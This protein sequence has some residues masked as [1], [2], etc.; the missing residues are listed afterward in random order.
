[1]GLADE[2]RE[3]VL[4]NYIEPARRWGESTVTVRAGDVH[5]AMGS[6]DRMPAVA[7]ALG[8]TSLSNTRMSG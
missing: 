1:M 5:K 2:I 4:V 7:G 8:A 6:K 3:Y